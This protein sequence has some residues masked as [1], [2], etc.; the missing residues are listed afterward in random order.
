MT[1]DGG[2]KV[3]A[4]WKMTF[5]KATKTYSITKDFAVDDGFGVRI[6]DGNSTTVQKAWYAAQAVS[7]SPA[8]FDISGSNI[9]C[10]TAGRYTVTCTLT[11]EG[12]TVAITATE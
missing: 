5:D 10:K 2:W 11:D 1:G 7:G 9:T 3:D 8:G 12:A 4:A 6:M